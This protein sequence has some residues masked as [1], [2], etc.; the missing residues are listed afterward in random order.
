[1]VAILYSA[2]ARLLIAQQ[3]NLLLPRPESLG[4]D[5]RRLRRR[6]AIDDCMLLLLILVV[7][8]ILGVFGHISERRVGV[9]LLVHLLWPALCRARVIFQ[10]SK[11]L[12]ASFVAAGLTGGVNLLVI[13]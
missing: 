3:K 7:K 8:V 13:R 10:G 6:A 1:M 11:R 9:C 12:L 5:R 2:P 4:A